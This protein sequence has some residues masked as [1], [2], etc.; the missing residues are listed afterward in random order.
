L[1]TKHL[2]QQAGRLLN[3]LCRHSQNSTSIIEQIQ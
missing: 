3:R 1:G 2:R